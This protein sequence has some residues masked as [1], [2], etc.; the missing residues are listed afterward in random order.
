MADIYELTTRSLVPLF[1]ALRHAGSSAR[2]LRGT[3]LRRRLHGSTLGRRGVAPRSRASAPVPSEQPQSSSADALRSWLLWQVLA[4]TFVQSFQAP[5]LVAPAAPARA[6]MQMAL[7]CATPT[8][9]FGCKQL[10]PHP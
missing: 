10:A 7:E 5:S 1:F 4:T 9:H 6:N 8:A 3:P 2:E